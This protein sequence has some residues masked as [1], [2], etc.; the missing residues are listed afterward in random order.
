[1]CKKVEV[2]EGISTLKV[3]WRRW[4]CSQRKEVKDIYICKGGNEGR[5][6]QEGGNR[7]RGSVNR[8]WGLKGCHGNIGG[9]GREGRSRVLDSQ[10]S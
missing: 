8:M 6:V 9:T 7:E 10:V 4:V 5:E 1:M 3:K 2:R